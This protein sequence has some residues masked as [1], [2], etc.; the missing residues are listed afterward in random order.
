MEKIYDTIPLIPL[1]GPAFVHGL[2]AVTELLPNKV[3]VATFDSAYHQS[4]K[5]SAYLYAI[6][7]IESLTMLLNTILKMY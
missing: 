7:E 3:Q 5:K 1:H 6:P 4:M 2:E